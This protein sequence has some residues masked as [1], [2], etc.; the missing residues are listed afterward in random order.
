MRGTDAKYMVCRTCQQS[1]PVEDYTAGNNDCKGCRQ[2]LANLKRVAET[3]GV[4]D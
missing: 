2:P 4:L 3:Q 1:K